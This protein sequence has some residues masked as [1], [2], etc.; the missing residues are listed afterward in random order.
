MGELFRLYAFV[1]WV[2]AI[3]SAVGLWRYWAAGLFEIPLI[4]AGCFVIALLLQSQAA[5]LTTWWAVGLVS[6]TALAVYLQIR[7][8]A[9][10]V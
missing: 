8:K 1:F 3:A 4:P 6:Q 10:P 7:L 5:T 9:G 2:P